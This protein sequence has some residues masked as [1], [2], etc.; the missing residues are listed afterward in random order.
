MSAPRTADRFARQVALSGFGRAGQDRLAAARA[1]VVGAGGL[2]SALLP[3]LVASGIGTVVVVDGDVVEV[4]NLHRQTLHGGRDL[5][6]AKAASAVAAL[7]MLAPAGTTLLAEP[8]FVDE[9]SVGALIAGADVVVDATDSLETRYLLDAATDAAAVPLVWGSATGTTGQVGVC[10][11]GSPRWRDLFPARPADDDVVTCAVGGVLPTLCTTIGGLMAT[12]VLKVLTGL[13]RPLA[14]RLLVVDALAPS[15]REIAFGAADPTEPMQEEPHM[16]ENEDV[17]VQEVAALL[18]RRETVQLVDVREPWEADIA[19]LPGAKLIPLG[20]L[21]DRIGELD[22][23]VPVITYCHHGM[24]S[25]D[26]ADRLAAA[27]FDARSMAGGID[28][29]SRRVDDTVPRY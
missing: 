29:W 1:V 20:S 8:R 6:T 9:T 10:L 25:A 24:R 27:G 3:V 5:G 22:P 14:G 21:Q 28:R 16:A 18:E 7:E 11:P 4:T 12:E 19:S 2:G 26:A 15:V 13:G 23:D 17:D